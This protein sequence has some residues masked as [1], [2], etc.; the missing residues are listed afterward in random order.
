MV[1]L[2]GPVRRTLMAFVK[3]PPG[4]LL[5]GRN[6]NWLSMNVTR[7]ESQAFNEL[8]SPWKPL[9]GG[10]EPPHLACSRGWAL[11]TSPVN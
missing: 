2:A 8:I 6:T 10:A 7:L 1:P 3:R 9:R 11:R 5:V 4:V